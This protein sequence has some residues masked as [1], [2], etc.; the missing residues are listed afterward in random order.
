MERRATPLPGPMRCIASG[1]RRRGACAGTSRET[2]AHPQ[3]WKNRPAPQ[4]V[5]ERFSSW[6]WLSPFNSL[7]ATRSTIGAIRRQTSNSLRTMS[8]TARSLTSPRS[9]TSF[10]LPLRS[11][12]SSRRTTSRTS[13]R[14]NS[15]RSMRGL[16]PDPFP[17][18]HSRAISYFRKGQAAIGVSPKLSVAC[19]ASRSS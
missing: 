18:V 16:P 12:R 19:R 3:V 17:M 15:I 8:T 11:F 13:T 2:P 6:A 7:A 10:R 9:S 5:A 4:G 14:S 1:V